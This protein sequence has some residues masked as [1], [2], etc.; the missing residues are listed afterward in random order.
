MATLRET[1]KATGKVN[2]KLFDKDG[3]LK[4]DRTIKNLVVTSGLEHIA[5][6]LA[7]SGI[8]AQM[9]HM[10]IGTG[11]DAPVLADPGLGYEEA[12]VALSVAGGTPSGTSITYAATFG[13]TVG[14]GAITEA[15]IFN[16]DGTPAGDMLCRTV[17]LPINK[18]ADDSLAVTWEVTIS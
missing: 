11:T 8:P 18:G 12:R 7:N 10:A 5:A 14:E 9:S 15:G 17:F 16:N 2:F 4:E 6:R 3:N 13:A 1:L